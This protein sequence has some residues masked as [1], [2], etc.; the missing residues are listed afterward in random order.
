MR[1]SYLVLGITALA[2]FPF[3]KF[4]ED[5]SYEMEVEKILRA[6]L[7]Q[8]SCRNLATFL[9]FFIGFHNHKF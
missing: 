3:L 9:S 2:L 8:N 5:D 6:H 7:Q 1:V 4:C